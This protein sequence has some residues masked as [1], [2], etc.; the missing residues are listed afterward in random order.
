MVK[1]SAMSALADC[2]SPT[3]GLSDGAYE[4]LIALRNTDSH[5]STWHIKRWNF[6]MA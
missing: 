1:L 3:G 5:D 6:M 2:W 4:F